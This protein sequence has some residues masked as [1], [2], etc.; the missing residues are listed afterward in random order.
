MDISYVWKEIQLWNIAD[1]RGL[2]DIYLIEYIPKLLG[3][4][5]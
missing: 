4:L 3:F 1:V 5:V 2:E